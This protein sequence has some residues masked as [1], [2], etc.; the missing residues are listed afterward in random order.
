MPCFPAHSKIGG[1]KSRT[2]ICIPARD[3]CFHAKICGEQHTRAFATREIGIPLSPELRNENQKR[4]D[5][6][7]EKENETREKAPEYI[8]RASCVA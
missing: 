5:K 6:K 3:R 1:Y 4:L 7:Q 2:F 8:A